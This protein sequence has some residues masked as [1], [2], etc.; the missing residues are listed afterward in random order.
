MQEGMKYSWKM[1]LE[2]LLGSQGGAEIEK[3]AWEL[4]FYSKRGR[5]AE[6]QGVSTGRDNF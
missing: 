2:E 3:V 6:S 4:F 5:Q 1:T